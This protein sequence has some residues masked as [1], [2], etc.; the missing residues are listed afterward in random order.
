MGKFNDRKK[1][2]D[3][4]DLQCS[5][6]IISWPHK[7]KRVSTLRTQDR[8]RSIQAYHFYQSHAE[9]LRKN[10][11]GGFL[12]WVSMRYSPPTA[13]KANL[14]TVLVQCKDGDR[15]AECGSILRLF[16]AFTSLAETGHRARVGSDSERPTYPILMVPDA[17]SS[18]DNRASGFGACKSHSGTF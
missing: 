6:K 3:S 4:P 15:L 1:N 16:F 5:A 9:R 10:R 13:R 8:W 17:T 7:R 14:P 11:K 18:G 2:K 12:T